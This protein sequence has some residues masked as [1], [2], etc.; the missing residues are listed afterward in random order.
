MKK[1]NK[2]QYRLSTQKIRWE[3]QGKRFAI[4][5]MGYEMGD[6][7]ERMEQRAASLFCLF[8]EDFGNYIIGL[9]E[10]L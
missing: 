2:K 6:R 10:Y 8:F 3:N 9:V 4:S 7:A 1:I 5:A